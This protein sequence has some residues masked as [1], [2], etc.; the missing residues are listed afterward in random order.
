MYKN[1][2]IILFSFATKD[3]KKSAQRLFKQANKTAYYDEIKILNPDSFSNEIKIFSNKLKRNEKKRGYGYWFWKPMIIKKILKEI[4]DGDILHYLDVGCHIQKKNNRFYE[5][6][7][8]LIGKNNWILPFQYFVSEKFDQ[9]IF[10]VPQRSEYQYTKSDLFHYFNSIK[11]RDITHTPQY[12]A[13]SFFLKKN[14]FSN[15]FLDQWIDVFIKNFNLVDDSPSK[16]DNFDGFIENRHDQSVFSLLCKLKKLTAISAYECDWVEKNEKRTWEHNNK[17]PILAKRDLEYS[18]L[19]RF[20]RRQ[21][22]TIGR[23]LKKYKNV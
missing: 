13:G 15:K 5:Y 22:K 12:W 1:T 9:K 10:S 16:I 8:F 6:L 3:L 17:N 18:I 2:K 20:L 11:D 14:I 21:K 23:L 19:K 4:K 7:D